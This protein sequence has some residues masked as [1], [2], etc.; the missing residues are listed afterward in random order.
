MAEGRVHHAIQQD[1]SRGQSAGN[2]GI[3]LYFVSMGCN[4]VAHV[5]AA[6]IR[7]TFRLNHCFP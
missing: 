2:V 6:Q 7:G 4:V 5:T 3:G 1:M